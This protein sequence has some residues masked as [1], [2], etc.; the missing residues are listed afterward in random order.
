MTVTR[1]APSPT[2]FLHIGGLRTALYNYLYAKKNNGKFILRIEDTDQKR[3]VEGAM[4]NLVN[5]LKW[6]DIE[7]DEGPEK[8]GE[9][10]PYVQS[11]RSDL[12]KK[13]AEQLLKE[14]HAY[15]CFC[16]AERLNEMREKQTAA[17]QPTMYDR[18]CLYLS[19]EEVNK[20]LE[21]GLPFV[22]R[23]KIPSSDV[24]K[25]N[26]L[27][28]GITS[29]SGKTIDDQILVKSDGFPTY[30]LANV[31]DDHLM[32]VTHVIRGDEWLPSTPKHILLYEAFGW[33]KPEF[34]HIPLLLNPDKTKLSKR[35][36]DVAAEDYMKKGYIKEAVLNF[37]AFLGWHPGGDLENE[38][39]TMEELIKNFSLEK[40]HKSGAIFDLEKLNWFNWQWQKQAYNKN[41]ETIAKELDTNVKIITKK[42]GELD[43]KFDDF[44]NSRQF[45]KKRGEELLKLCKKYLSDDIKSQNEL[46]LKALVSIEEKILRETPNTEDYLGF[47]FGDIS[48]EKDLFP[49]EKMKVD[50]QIAIQA[51]KAGL[52]SLQQLDDF[53]NMDK[54]RDVLIEAVEK[55]GISNGQML[56]PLRCA[57]TGVKYSP[58]VFEVAWVLGKKESLKRIENGLNFLEKI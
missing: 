31:V 40:V 44:E 41:L 53:E 27:I 19:E 9:N 37:I 46:L 23:Q 45:N 47:Y 15:K 22:I 28:H 34:A 11:E 16:T 36:G 24:V 52:E 18:Q 48:Y 39:M 7:F 1:F 56:W 42:K 33:G 13:Y 14:G 57:L 6:F 32:G 38:I 43:Y 4:E 51:L 10:G 2:G 20:K 25:F 8:G 58:G 29:F 17:K 5:T 35:Q 30:H 55:E 54:I 21:E 26:D 3:L 50:T 12:Y 49:H